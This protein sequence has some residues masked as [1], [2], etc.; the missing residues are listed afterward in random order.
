[1]ILGSAIVLLI[2]LQHRT[3]SLTLCSSRVELLKDVRY[4][5]SL[6]CTPCSSFQASLFPFKH[7]TNSH[8]SFKAQR[9]KS[10]SVKLSLTHFPLF[11]SPVYPNYSDVTFIMLYGSFNMSVSPINCEFP[12]VSH[13]S[14][15]VPITHAHMDFFVC[16]F[17]LKRIY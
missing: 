14:N 15:R 1:M 13:K 8:A 16:V 2:C 11:R 12:E 9:S 7:L 6:L 4:F 17:H 5:A 3:S 10:S